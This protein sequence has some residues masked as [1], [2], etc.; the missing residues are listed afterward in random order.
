MAAWDIRCM[1]NEG[2]TSGYGNNTLLKVIQEMEK[3][4]VLHSR[5]FGAEAVRSGL[6]Y[7]LQNV[8]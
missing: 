8:S 5:Y 3:K 7:Q 1:M 2:K 6:D 4:D